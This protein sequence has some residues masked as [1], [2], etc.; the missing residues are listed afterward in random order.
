MNDIGIQY[1][2]RCIC[3]ISFLLFACWNLHEIVIWKS[4]EKM[5]IV[6]SSPRFYQSENIKFHFRLGQKPRV[7]DVKT[8]TQ[9]DISF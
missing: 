2:L 9:V 7:S 6:V 4:G 1:I 5:D 3:Q 8:R